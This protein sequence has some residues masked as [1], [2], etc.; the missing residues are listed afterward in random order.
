MAIVEFSV[1]DPILFNANPTGR[2][3]SFGRITTS[4]RIGLQKWVSG[5][6]NPLGNRPDFHLNLASI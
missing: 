1:P 6:R 2:S 4:F 3:V 5:H